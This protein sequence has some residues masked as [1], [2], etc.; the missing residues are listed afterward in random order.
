MEVDKI[1]QN[2]DSRIMDA[3]CLAY[4]IWQNKKN[5]KN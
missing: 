3:G 4:T 1:A 2:K 5:G